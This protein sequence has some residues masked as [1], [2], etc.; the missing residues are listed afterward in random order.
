[1]KP[2]DLLVALVIA[3]SLCSGALAEDASTTTESPKKRSGITVPIDADVAGNGLRVFWVP[4]ISAS[5]ESPVRFDY[6]VA[7]LLKQEVFLE[8]SGRDFSDLGYELQ[9][10]EIDGGVS[11]TSGGGGMTMFPDN[12]N[13]LKRVHAATYRDGKAYFCGCA[14][15]NV[16][17]A[18]EFEDVDLAEW[19]GAEGTVT[20]RLK[21]FFRENGE[22][23]S[24]SVDLPIKI[25]K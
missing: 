5:A 17:A 20:V 21:G 16:K 24:E 4:E 8:V 9:R 14:I 12:L 2:T 25:A 19:I 13:L 10:V 3:G 18:I 11:W 22:E 15:T 7:N 6:R 1:M 23:F